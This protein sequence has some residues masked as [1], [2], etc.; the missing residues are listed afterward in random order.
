MGQEIVLI[1]NSEVNDMDVITQAFSEIDIAA[2][3]W[4]NL[5]EAELSDS[6][7]SLM[8]TIIFWEM[9]ELPGES[10]LS[11]FDLILDSGNSISVFSISVFSDNEDFFVN[12]FDTVHIRNLFR[13]SIYQLD[14]PENNWSF[15][16]SIVVTELGWIGSGEPLFGY[17]E[18]GEYSIILKEHQTGKTMSVG[19]FLE[20]VE[21]LPEFLQEL[22]GKLSINPN[23]L[24]IGNTTAV[25]GDTVYIPITITTEESVI[26]LSFTIQS[27]PENLQFVSME[28]DTLL[29]NFVWEINQLPFGIVEVSGAAVYGV[30]DSGTSPLGSLK[31]WLYPS[32]SDKIGIRGIEN[33]IT[34]ESGESASAEMINGEI[35]VLFDF[36]IVELIPP[37][38]I[39]PGSTGIVDI[40]LITEHDIIALQFCLNYEQNLIGISDVLKTSRIPDFW[41]VSFVNYGDINKSEIFCFGFSPMIPGSGPILEVTFDAYT[42]DPQF[43]DIDFCD[44]LLASTDS[45]G[46]NNAAFGTSLLVSYPDII[47]SAQT[48]ISDNW[49]DAAIFVVAESQF[50]GFQ[51][52]LK[53][54]QNLSV[55]NIIT[56]N[57]LENPTGGWNLIDENTLRIIY[58]QTTPVVDQPQTGYLLTPSFMINE[59]TED[60]IFE[61]EVDNFNVT[62]LSTGG[63]PAIFTDFSVNVMPS[64]LG[65]VN[66]DLTMD[67]SDIVIMVH[68][69]LETLE[70]GMA[71]QIVGDLNNDGILD[72]FDIIQLVNLILND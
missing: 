56:G 71:Q 28:S 24:T 57:I 11:Q 6:L 20:P 64:T 47:V 67:I 1:G 52:D 54:P 5:P 51:I 7:L 13:D 23:E 37:S 32:S 31:A 69:I 10:I 25:P 45:E 48:I 14:S 70:P 62:D 16:D 35:D 49:L 46:I 60:E 72:V 44:V 18:L 29:E 3:V 27:D 58:F 68:F 34:L 43:V 63:I 66:G 15:Y 42:D 33:I 61:F 40:D 21:E 26:G 59:D 2:R 9:D 8:Q 55:A 12:H 38:L 65:D 39:E 41:W 19:F 50:T 30:L 17:T 22:I 36:S 4:D 53:F